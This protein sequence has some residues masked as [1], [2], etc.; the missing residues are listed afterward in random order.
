MD[1]SVFKR[2]KTVKMLIQS[3]NRN[4]NV[5]Y[6]SQLQRCV[7]IEETDIKVRTKFKSFHV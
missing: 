5:M 7:N 4:S 2:I 1:S 6:T 3:H